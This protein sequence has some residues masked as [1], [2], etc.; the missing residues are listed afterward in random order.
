MP[1]EISPIA[2]I[3]SIRLVRFWAERKRSFSNWKIAQITARPITTR[4]EARSPWT[5]RRRLARASSPRKPVRVSASRA[6]SASILTLLVSPLPLVFPLAALGIL[7]AEAG[8]RRDD[9]LLGRLVG[10][11]LPGGAAEPEH[12]DPVGD[13]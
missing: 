7:L 10:L 1:T 6:P 5:R 4:K 9:V 2:V 12:E 3:W 11:E 13:L 8:D